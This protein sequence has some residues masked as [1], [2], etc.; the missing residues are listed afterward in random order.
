MG[1]FLLKY[2]T[3]KASEKKQKQK[4]LNLTLSTVHFLYNTPHYI[5]DLDTHVTQSSCGSQLFLYHC[6]LQ[7]NYW[8]MTIKWS[9]S[10]KSFVK[11]SLYLE[12]S[13]LIT[14]SIPIGP[15]Y[16]VIN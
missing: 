1:Q 5:M 4:K 8:K 13:S 11:L 2:R 7:R 16:R 12:H 14:L 15:K 10:Y 9:F 3:V 6:I